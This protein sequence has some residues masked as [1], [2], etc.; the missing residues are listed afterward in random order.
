MVLLLVG[1]HFVW[2]MASGLA[3]CWSMTRQ[4]WAFVAAAA[5]THL[6]STPLQWIRSFITLCLVK[7]RQ[8]WSASMSR[9][10]SVFEVCTGQ[11]AHANKMTAD[12][13]LR[14]AQR[15]GLAAKLQV[16]RCLICYTSCACSY[17]IV[18]LQGILQPRLMQLRGH[19]T[20][21]P[22]RCNAMPLHPIRSACS[23]QQ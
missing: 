21:A 10:V 9:I 14:T 6:L 13:Q 8:G 16:L 18:C 5:R 23:R 1:F 22:R 12:L 17:N 4:A 3:T 7:A 15:D 19:R 2:H 11:A 20:F